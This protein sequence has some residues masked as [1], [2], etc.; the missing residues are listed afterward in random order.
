MCVSTRSDDADKANRKKQE[1][2]ARE[3]INA[4][5][6]ERDAKNRKGGWFLVALAVVLAAGLAYSAKV[7]ISSPPQH[8]CEGATGEQQIAT[9]ALAQLISTGQRDAAVTEY[10]KYM[11]QKSNCQVL[12]D[13]NH[14]TTADPTDYE[15]HKARVEETAAALKQAGF[16]IT[17]ATYKTSGKGKHAEGPMGS[18]PVKRITVSVAQMCSQGGSA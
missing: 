15:A 1:Q 5:A 4:R 7:V 6:A 17:D 16:T 13:V 3:R 14:D 8:K 10:K 9:C 2:E 11:A 12:V 18:V